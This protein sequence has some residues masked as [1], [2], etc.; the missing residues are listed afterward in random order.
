[1]TYC[2][3]TCM[4]SLHVQL[5]GRIIGK[6]VVSNKIGIATC[7]SAQGATSTTCSWCGAHLFRCWIPNGP[8]PPACR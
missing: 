2:L 7:R 4:V 6:H 3:M 5:R 1:M 8:Q